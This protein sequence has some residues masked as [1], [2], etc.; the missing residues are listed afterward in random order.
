M[1]DTGIFWRLLR[2]ALEMITDSVTVR[3][4]M[5]V[6]VSCSMTPE[7]TLPSFLVRTWSWKLSPTTAFGSMIFS[8]K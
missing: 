4:V 1:R 7:K 6:S 2:S 3:A 8:R 5:A